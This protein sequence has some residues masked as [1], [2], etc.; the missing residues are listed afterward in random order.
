MTQQ[1]LHQENVI[2]PFNS[3]ELQKKFHCNRSSLPI[4]IVVIDSKSN[5]GMVQKRA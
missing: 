2:I 4:W 3:V 5:L 1:G